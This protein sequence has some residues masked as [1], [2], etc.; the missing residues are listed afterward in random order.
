MSGKGV[1]D[2]DR[3]TRDH[4]RSPSGSPDSGEVCSGAVRLENLIAILSE[5]TKWAFVLFLA[6]SLLFWI[7]GLAGFQIISESGTYRVSVLGNHPLFSRAGEII[8]WDLLLWLL[9]LIALELPPRGKKNHEAL[10]GFTLCLF[11]WRIVFQNVAILALPSMLASQVQNLPPLRET[12]LFLAPL[13]FGK[14][15]LFR[16]FRSHDREID[17]PILELFSWH[18]RKDAI[19]NL[20]YGATIVASTLNLNSSR[21]FFLTA[22]VKIVLLGTAASCISRRCWDLLGDTKAKG[23]ET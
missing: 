12:V 1:T 18:H 4:P 21:I 16:F 6:I 7:S 22:I 5:G 2:G 14:E 9:A 13:V 8:L 19:F 10:I 15:F 23:C 17:S 20:L 11:L 3:D